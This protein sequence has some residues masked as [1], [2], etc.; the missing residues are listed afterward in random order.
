MLSTLMQYGQ[1]AC[2][3]K[4]EYGFTEILSG[5]DF[6]RGGRSIFTS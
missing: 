3:S 2:V 4:I 6:D 5:A 1:M